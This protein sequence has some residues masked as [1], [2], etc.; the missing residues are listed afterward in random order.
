[1][2]GHQSRDRRS[3]CDRRREQEEEQPRRPRLVSGHRRRMTRLTSGMHLAPF[4][5]GP[6]VEDEHVEGKGH[7]KMQACVDQAG[8]LAVKA[9]FRRRPESGK[10]AVLAK[11]PNRVKMVI[12]CRALWP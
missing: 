1:M 11:P 6:L 2:H 8:A 12:G 9:M 5:S 3:E 4:A 10:L 7:G